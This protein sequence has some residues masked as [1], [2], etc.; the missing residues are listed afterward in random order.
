MRPPA[1]LAP[2]TTAAASAARLF[3][4]VGVRAVSILA[5]QTPRRLRGVQGLDYNPKVTTAA[6]SAARL[7]SRVGVRA[8]SILAHPHTWASA[9]AARDAAR[10]LSWPG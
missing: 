2:A 5:H 7:F 9:R 10:T 1:P 4:R 6:A 3:S 8:V